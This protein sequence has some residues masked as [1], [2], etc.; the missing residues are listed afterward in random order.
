[1]ELLAPAGS[2][3]C[4]HAAVSA[5]A[6]A[7]YLGCDAFNA[8]RG[9]DNFT[10]DN[11]AAAC[12]YAHLRGV[13]IYLTL[14]IAIMPEEVET[15][16]ELA[17][18]AWRRGVDAFIVQDIGLA[19]EIR[20]ALPHARLHIST[21]MNTHNVDGV[22]AAAAFEAQRVTMARELSLAELAEVTAEAH[23]LG[24]E[25]ECFAHGAL[26]VCYSGQCLMSSMIGGRSANRGTCAQACRLPYALRDE[27]DDVEIPAPG[28]RLLSPK[29]LCTI[30]MLPKL[31][32]TGVDSLKIE[33]RM[34][35]PEY[36][37]AVVAAYRAALDRLADAVDEETPLDEAGATEEEHRALSEA[38]SRGF[39]EAYLARKRGNDIMGYGRPNNRGVFAGRV[40]KA[41]GH[42]VAIESQAELHEGDVLEFWT[43]KGHFASTLEAFERKGDTYYFE[44]DGRVGK[45]DRVFRVR[46]ASMAFHDDDMEPRLPV[47]M[48]VTAHIGEPL[49]FVARCAGAEA[50]FEGAVVEAARTKAISADEVR[51]HVDRLGN[52]PFFLTDLDVDVDNGVG[53]GFSAL[54]KART[55]ALRALSEAMLDPWRGRALEKAGKRTRGRHA[56]THSTEDA[57]V[58]AFATNPACARAAKKA[59]ADTVF[60]SALHYRRGE[61]CAEG[62]IVDTPEQAGYPGRCS[63]AMPV[64]DKTPMNSE[65]PIDMWKWAKPGKPL[66]VENLGQLVR[67]AEMGANVEAGPHLPITNAASLAAAEALGARRVWLSPELSL[68]QIAELGAASPIEL[69]ITVCGNQELMTCEHCLLMSQGACNQK[70]SQCERRAHAHTLL[71][72]KGYRFPVVTDCFGRSHLY[73]AVRFDAV[74][75]IDELIDAGVTAFMVDTTLMSA[76]EAAR[77]TSRVVRAIEA[78]KR[79]AN[80]AKA[81]GCTTGHLFRGVQ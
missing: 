75:V 21:Q 42:E 57:T 53:M 73:N 18:Q 25:T 46:D 27:D 29:D 14:N 37:Y 17:R 22:R 54:H 71:D 51:E 69:G 48:S 39:T 68:K 56:T 81:E 70:C 9:A 10:L 52:T 7:V 13:R 43:N 40:A 60:V 62:R 33:G 59:G 67:G 76:D 78:A 50:T 79:G 65:E 1:M 77:A 24:M 20:R 66:F 63:I 49:R 16:L 74:H 72:R 31:A 36:V 47:R 32:E 44:V 12:D 6:D 30:D 23:R 61:A 35:S 11:L 64:V 38:F 8:R 15:A 5:G 41:K 2:P 26:C 28:D 34:K 55:Q 3:A 58:V 45:G 19:A 80:V 4:L